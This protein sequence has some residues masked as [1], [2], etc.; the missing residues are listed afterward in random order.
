MP[1][2]TALD[3][4]TRLMTGCLCLLL[5]AALTA[6]TSEEAAKAYGN[7]FSSHAI[8]W[9][10][11]D[12]LD[13][14]FDAIKD[15]RF[16]LLGESSHGTR[17]FYVWRDQISR[18]LI[19]QKGFDF[20]AVEGD[21]QIIERLNGYVKHRVD[22]D[23]G[24]TG[25]MLEFKRWPQWLWANREFAE[26]CEWLRQHNAG[27]ELDRRVGLFGLDLQDPEASADAVLEWFHQHNDEHHEKVRKAYDAFRNLPDSFPGYARHLADGGQ[28]LDSE[29]GLAVEL[30]GRS[31]EP[32]DKHD[33]SA[34]QNAI[35][36]RRFEKH[37]HDA[38]RRGQAEGW[39]RRAE[40]FHQTLLRV[41]EHHGEQAHGVVWA[42]NTHVGDASATAMRAQG[43]VN[44]G[45]LLRQSEG[46]EAV[47]IV[48]LTTHGGEVIAGQRQGAGRQVQEMGTP[49]SGSAE[50]M[51]HE[52]APKKAMILFGD[53]TR[54]RQYLAPLP[55]RAI[56]IVHNPARE[57]HVPTLLPWRYDALIFID[58]TSA[59]TPLH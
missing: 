6:D 39:N 51:L 36:I 18:R 34:R 20:V 19:E 48:G 30:L 57:A 8:E 21:W 26:F 43:Q 28:R 55:H 45:Q 50:A 53:E 25:L 44:I 16:V 15:R 17:E 46:P 54:E 1:A 4:M 7:L 42:H 49:L 40:H 59:L 5:A 35:A 11:I 3:R 37:V 29:A 38:V 52:H 27:L 14:L 31:A 9:A 41:V 32:E 47:F 23:D 56:G 12:D 22:H 33:W 58:Q 10:S 13:P 24:V 2:L